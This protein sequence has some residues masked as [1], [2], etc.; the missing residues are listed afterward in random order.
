MSDSHSM[1]IRD[2]HLDEDDALTQLYL[3]DLGEARRRRVWLGVGAIVLLFSGAA[4]IAVMLLS[5]NL[6]GGPQTA[7]ATVAPAPAV[8]TPAP[9]VAKGEPVPVLP[10]EPAGTTIL[11]KKAEPPSPEQPAPA[12]A[13]PAESSEQFAKGYSIDLGSALSFSELSRRFG[14]IARSNQ[15]IPFDTLEPRATLTDTPQ[16]LEARLIVG[17]FTTKAE[18]EDICA[19]I[20]LPAGVQCSTAPFEGELISRQ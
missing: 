19:R 15:E 9:P 4:A 3:R 10:K 11:V 13:A 18:A 2:D 5:P 14:E 1:D 16:G 7:T 8:E 20:A 6:G 12:P 17:P